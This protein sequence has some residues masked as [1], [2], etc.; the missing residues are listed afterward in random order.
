MSRGYPPHELL[1][2]S[3]RVP[4][5]AK[6]SCVQSPLAASTICPLVLMPEVAEAVLMSVA[7]S[8]AYD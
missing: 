3:V 6:T 4:L 2:A 5:V 7:R 1:D 8:E